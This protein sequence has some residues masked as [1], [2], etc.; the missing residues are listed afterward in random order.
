MGVSGALTS[1]ALKAARVLVVLAVGLVPGVAVGATGSGPEASVAAAGCGREW[2][3]PEHIGTLPSKLLEVSG[4]VS[5]ARYPGRGLDDPGL[6]QPAQPL[7]LHAR[8]RRSP[9]WKE[10]SCPG[11]VQPRLGGP[12]L[13]RR[14]RRPGPPVDLRERCRRPAPRRSTR[15]SSPTPDAARAGVGRA[16]P[17][18]VEYPGRTATPRPSSPSAA[19]SRSCRR[20]APTV[21][22]GS[23]RPVPGGDE[24][25]GGRRRRLDVGAFLTMTAVSADERTAMPR[26]TPRRRRGRS[27]T[28][29][30]A[31]S[32]LLG[33]D[34]CSAPT[35]PRASGRRATS[36]P[37]T[38]ATSS[39]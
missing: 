27:R 10:F 7:L 14:R 38:A 21:S 3:E 18:G 8:R 16:T 22:T 34:P 39:W 5:S 25:A 9:R 6:R 1:R 24:P 4:F 15:S 35:W 26:V 20:P 11:R 29:M 31:T 12:G 32:R 30:A 36:S 23:P 13:H 17:T 19:A 37:T 28:P 33:P 2:Q